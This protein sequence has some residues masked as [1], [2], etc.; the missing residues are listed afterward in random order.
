MQSLL[1]NFSGLKI[2][3]KIL[4]GVIFPLVMMLVVGGVGIVNIRA[5]IQSNKQLTAS[6]N[7]LTTSSDVLLNAGDMVQGVRGYLLA[8][9][10]AFLSPYE[11]GLR[12][13]DTE[14]DKLRTLVGNDPEAHARL[15]EAAEILK[16]W[17]M[18]VA[19][20]SMELRREI[21]DAETMNDMARLIGKAEGK[22]YFDEIRSIITSFVSDQVKLLEMRRK[23]LSSASIRI[24]DNVS[25][26]HLL[27]E[28]LDDL[29]EQTEPLERMQAAAGA[30]ESGLRD[31]V[32]SSRKEGLSTFEDERDNFQ[33]AVRHLK[34]SLTGRAGKLH[35]VNGLATLINNWDEA[36]VRSAKQLRARV[37]SGDTTVAE[38]RKFYRQKPG[39][40]VFGD[41]RKGVMEMLDANE[42][43]MTHLVME[44][45]DAETEAESAV[46]VMK[47]EEIQVEALY[48]T[49]VDAGNVLA[50]AINMETGMR[51]YLLAGQEAFLEPY[52][53]GR[54]VFDRQ[55]QELKAELPDQ[56]E[57][58]A[59]LDNAS[60]IL[61]EWD[62]RV[63]QPM[64]QLRRKIG[65]AATMD[66]MADLV[67]QEKGREY[68]DQFRLVMAEFI[69]DE[70]RVIAEL[71]AENLAIQQRT[72]WMVG[73]CTVLALVL[74]LGLAVLVGNGISRPLVRMTGE[75]E[76]LADGDTG[77]AVTGTER[78][79][80]IGAMA[81]TLQVFRDNAVEN[82]RLMAEQ[83]RQQK[84][85]EDR[86]RK[87]AERQMAD[88]K[89]RAI[90]AETAEQDKRDEEVP[91]FNA[92]QGHRPGACEDD[93]TR[94]DDLFHAEAG[95]QV[96]SEEG[97]HI[98]CQHMGGDHVGRVA[99]VEAAAH[100]RQRGG[101][102]HQVHQRVGHHGADHCHGDARRRQ[103][104]VA[105]A[106]ARRI[107]RRDRG[108]RDVEQEEQQRA[109]HVD[110]DDG[111]IGAHEGHDHRIRR[112]LDHL[113]PDQGGDQPAR[114]HVG[115]RL[116]PVGVGGGVGGGEAVEAVGRH[117]EP[118]E[119][120]A[121]QEEREGGVVEADRPDDAADRAAERAEEKP[122]AAAVFLHDGRYRRGREHGAQHDERDR[123]RRETGVRGQRLARQSADGEDHR[124][125]RPEDRLRGHQNHHVALGAAVV[126]HIFRL[127][128]ARAVACV[129]AGRKMARCAQALMPG[130]SDVRK[131]PRPGPRAGPWAGGACRRDRWQGRAD[132][133][134]D[135]ASSPLPP[136]GHGR[137]RSWGRG[138]R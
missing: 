61:S 109:E 98:H 11:S 106:A 68:M 79:D 91:E 135:K 33:I 111:K 40:A 25:R 82:E 15:N 121:E 67:G 49:V 118:G 5:I 100:H 115:D 28:M 108:L 36:A 22:A 114:H 75:M 92:L 31:Y 88:E 48:R 87:D 113:R 71:Q 99:L 119:E 50:S 95:D 45:R 73:G 70:Q 117:V 27:N 10:D 21:G 104:F 72:Y 39:I 132:R 52:L 54:K 81:A 102:H 26:L 57:Q 105:G 38:V 80:E 66:D 8:G 77:I 122:R 138:W 44:R 6:G 93:E 84:A 20:P 83:K 23:R 69:S 94:G 101:G 42:K 136:H 3:K 130:R 43:R 85:S 34:K 47:F 16:R 103:Q 76:K 59:R 125:L 124:H 127:A 56:P 58:L 90:Q 96:A 41:V 4:F 97:G 24:E 74:G 133:R 12:Q 55:M 60:N 2:Q 29:R 64:I 53:A 137:C 89:A 30:M 19:A 128:H 37:A 18:D 63:V 86:D 17:Q 78:R 126:G 62:S 134:F 9:K 51:G 35:R 32:I 112:D 123:Q 46:V 110:G 13:T 7:L 107:L 1:T 120:G 116:G 129:A 65:A 131:S 14:I